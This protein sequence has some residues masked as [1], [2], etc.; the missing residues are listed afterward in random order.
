[1]P[2]TAPAGVPA[3]QPLW[4]Q[5]EQ[6]ASMASKRKAGGAGAEASND[7]GLSSPSKASSSERGP[8][9]APPEEVDERAIMA[10]ARQN[11]ATGRKPLVPAFQVGMVTGAVMF[12]WWETIVVVATHVLGI[13]LVLYGVYRQVMHVMRLD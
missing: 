10:A 1:L 4:Q 8:I 11:M 9:A 2:P 3:C 6:Q 13:S 12:D 7:V 5:P